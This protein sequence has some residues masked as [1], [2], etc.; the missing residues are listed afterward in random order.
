M[1]RF[2]IDEHVARHIELGKAIHER[3]SAHARGV[4]NGEVETA[5]SHEAD[6]SVPVNRK[7]S[8]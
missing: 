2:S 6:H 7:G 8:I 1:S 5:F 4:I 3:R